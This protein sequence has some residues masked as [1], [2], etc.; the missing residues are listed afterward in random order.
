[1]DRLT[2]AYKQFAERIDA[3]SLRERGM[4]F[5]GV[6]GILF[7]IVNSAVFPRLQAEEKALQTTLNAKQQ[8]V[9]A[10]QAYIREAAARHGT[11]PNAAA[12]A[13]I[14]SLKKL[15]DGQAGVSG[16]VSPAEMAKLVRAVLARHGSVSLVRLQNVPAE[17]FGDNKGP[18]ITPNAIPGGTLAKPT[19]VNTEFAPILYKHGVRV[20]VEGR[21]PDLVSY[22]Q[23]LERLPWRVMWGEVELSVEKHPTSR[24][25]IVLY[26][27]SADRAWI[28]M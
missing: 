5:A 17:P 12:R 26:T 7:A 3:L 1:M 20:E 24:L 15:I 28:G 27:L 21:Y 6:L 10:L 22:L 9:A 19:P 11:D 25:T 23:S 13:R 18:A 14:A 8:Q 16:V 2:A 4:V